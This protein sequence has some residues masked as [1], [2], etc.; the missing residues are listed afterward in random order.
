MSFQREVLKLWIDTD[1]LSAQSI[2]YRRMSANLYKTKN[3]GEFYHIHGSLEATTTLNMIGLEGF[4]P[5][6]TDYEEIIKVIE[7][8]VQKYSVSELEEMN[9]E[10]RQAGVPALKHEEFI[11]TPHVSFYYPH[12][13]SNKSLTYTPG[14][15]Q[16]ARTCMESHSTPGQPAPNPIPSKPQRQQEDTRRCQG[17]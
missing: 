15:T 12:A 5:D 14:Q 3:P 17:P 2:G 9:N 8:Q 1:L 11:K 4:R 7:G 10:R 16:R 13:N 6:L